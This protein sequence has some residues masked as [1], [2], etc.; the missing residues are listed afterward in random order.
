MKTEFMD[1]VSIIDYLKKEGLEPVA[2]RDVEKY[3]VAA[4]VIRCEQGD[5]FIVGMGTKDAKDKQITRDEQINVLVDGV[6]LC[7]Q[8][9]KKS[10]RLILGKREAP[11]EQAEVE[12]AVALLI[13]SMKMDDFK[14]EAEVDGKIVFLQPKSFNISENDKTERWMKYLTRPVEVPEFL[15]DLERAVNDGIFKW[16]RNVTGNYWSGRV[17][18][19]EVC[20]VDFNDNK[21]TLDVGKEGKKGNISKT[22]EEF[23]R[24]R[25]K[26]L[27]TNTF[28]RSQIDQVVSVIRTVAN[29][30]RYGA[31]NEYNREHLLESQVLC[32]DLDVV[33]NSVSLKPVCGD[34][35]FQFPALWK[36]F[37]S[38]RFIDVLMRIDNIPYV[39]ELKE[40]HSPGQYYRHAITQ[41]V[42][43]REFI[44]RAEKVHPWFKERG[45]DPE[46]CRAV[47]AF[48]E[49]A[50]GNKKHQKLL[51]Q[52]KKVAS[53]FDVE[54]IEIQGFKIISKSKKKS[55]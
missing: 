39:V 55:S 12:N 8:Q 20:T 24:I 53:C 16:Y 41:A 49:L 38:A 30:R 31:L 26:I 54:I 19:L 47:V 43:Y 2:K 22:R 33:S 28:S 27:D 21:Y 37:A 10:L 46:K 35:P 5:T 4:N 44:K 6:S 42:L 51:E 3:F 15:N 18:G 14:I 34:Y 48:P 9:N 7:I 17:G 1:N 32:S 25:N 29:S 11:G 23:L 40:G 13:E 36:P 52:H 50:K 45:L